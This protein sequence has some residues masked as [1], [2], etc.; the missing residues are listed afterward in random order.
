MITQIKSN[1]LLSLTKYPVRVSR[2]AKNEKTVL[3]L[4]MHRSG[5][6]M[7]TSVVQSLGVDIGDDLLAAVENDN[8]FGYFEDRDFIKLNDRILE[9]A[10]GNFL[11]P[12]AR[13]QILRAGQLMQKEIDQAIKSRSGS[14]MWGWKDPRT[15][16]TAELY[17][18]KLKNPYII[19][20]RRNYEAVAKSIVK[21]GNLE[22]VHLAAAVAEEYNRR[23]DEL[24]HG[25]PYIP[26]LELDYDEI[27]ANPKKAV[28]KIG[29]FLK[30][31]YDRQLYADAAEKIVPEERHNTTDDFADTAFYSLPNILRKVNI[32]KYL[33]FHT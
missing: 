26:R 33:T 22:D 4:G 27:I 32:F 19:V 1:K 8:K 24:L 18:P 10:G 23:I 5:T 29:L 14:P 2:W 9:L 25:M 21:R 31:P 30:I 12:P 15:S 7:T 16:L 3:V 13:Y 28:R 6:S 17:L 20:C 11:T